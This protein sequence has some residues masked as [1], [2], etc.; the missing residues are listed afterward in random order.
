[1]KKQLIYLKKTIYRK[2]YNNKK[3]YSSKKED[4]VKKEKSQKKQIGFLYPQKK[5]ITYKTQSKEAKKSAILNQKD[6]EKAKDTNKNM[7]KQKN[8]IVQ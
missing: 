4:N 8:G 2:N 5:P 6:F 7:L 3:K 1:M